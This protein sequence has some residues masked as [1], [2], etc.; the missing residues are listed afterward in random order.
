MRQ[1]LAV[2]ASSLL[3]WMAFPP[4]NWG[5]LIF[6]APVPLLWVMRRVVTPREAGWLGFLFGFAFWGSM[7]WWIRILGFVAWLPLSIVM[8]LWMTG[9][10]LLMF[11]ARQW[12]AWRWWGFTIGSWA[13]VEFLRARVPLGGFPWGNAGYP[14]GTLAWPRGSAQWIGASGW[15]VI[16]VAFAAAVIVMFDQERDRRPLELSIGI[17]LTLTVLG[18][19]FSPDAAGQAVRVAVVQGNSPCPRVHCDNEKQLIYDAH[20]ALTAEIPDASADLIVWGEDSFGGAYNPTFNGDVRRQMAAEA[21]RIGG[22][23]LAGGTR[24]GVPGTFDNYNILFA[25]SGEVVG[26]YLKQHP[27]PFGEFV[28][29]RQVLA[30]I[31]QLNQVPNDMNRGP[32]PVVFPFTVGATQ[33]VIG[34]VISFEGAFARHIRGEVKAGAQLVVVATNEGSYGAG[35]A[36]DQLIGMVRMSAA[37]LGV[38]VVHVAVTGR[39]TLIR[40]DGSVGRQ[41]DLF[42]ADVLTGIVNLQEAPRTVYAVLGDWLQLLAILAAIGVAISTARG[43]ARDFRIRPDLR[44]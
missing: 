25:P 4:L 39:S 43:P 34:S 22:Y 38:D 40:A 12:S 15:A 26:E 20:I 19:L 1:I 16:V 11:Y 31:P 21:V 6:V 27:V 44:R 17:I 41:T 32:G 35:S 30:F 8:A 10:A 3:M 13:L 28:P 36:S 9:W 33:G 24:P 29:F 42:T 2:L 14:I 37:S 23:F 18:A 5:F 7:L